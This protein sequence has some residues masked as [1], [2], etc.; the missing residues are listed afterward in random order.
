MRDNLHYTAFTVL[1]EY[2]FDIWNK[3][4]LACFFSVFSSFLKKHARQNVFH[5]LGLQFTAAY[6][7]KNV[8][9]LNLNHFSEA[10][11]PQNSHQ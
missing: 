8:C 10:S 6:V 1:I 4:F 5:H 2:K 11:L 7:R 3:T 9:P